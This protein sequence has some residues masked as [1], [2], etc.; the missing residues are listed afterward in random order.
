MGFELSQSTANKVKALLT[1]G[2][3]TGATN[4]NGKSATRFDIH[5]KVTGPAV[6]GYY[7]CVT[8]DFNCDT[9]SWNEYT[10]T[11]YCFPANDD[12]TLTENNRYRAINYGVIDDYLI[13]AVD[14]NF[15]EVGCFLDYDDSTG[16][17]GVD[18]VALA[19]CGLRV[20]NDSNSNGCPTL[21][22]DT[23]IAS[24]MEI[25][26]GGE[27]TLSGGPCSVTLTQPVT[28]YT[29][30]LNACGV[31]IGI[32]EGRTTSATSTVST[33]CCNCDSG[34]SSSSSSEDSCAG[35]YC[36]DVTGTV[37]YLANCAEVAAYDCDSSD[38]SNSDSSSSSADECTGYY[39]CN[40][41][42]TWVANCADLAARSCTGGSPS[43]TPVLC[44][45]V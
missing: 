10:A 20:N 17:L 29:F 26:I 24:T 3:G 40:G 39:C 25:T 15:P 30:K 9:E 12:A 1:R 35:W 27:A 38:S 18:V 21:E 19:G 5:V 13:F 8:T 28:N 4:A 31:V 6:D 23:D 41:V 34:S 11:S 45:I 36:C 32:E 7:P 16:E 14:V 33:D 2:T 37:V 44:E 22:V 43:P 42:N